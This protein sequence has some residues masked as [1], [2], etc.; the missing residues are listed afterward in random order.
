MRRALRSKW[1]LI[2]G[3]WLVQG[4]LAYFLWPVLVSGQVQPDMSEYLHT[5]YILWML[6]ILGSLMVLQS[7]FVL[8]V[9]R[10]RASG[11]GAW[12]RRLHFGLS[13]L[14]IGIM[15]GAVT[16]AAAAVL[17]DFGVNL[18]ID[19]DTWQLWFWAPLGISWP[20]AS[21][22]LARRCGRATPLR[23]SLLIAGLAAGLLVGGFV[24][25]IMS[26]IDLIGWSR[27]M[28]DEWLA[29]IF[30]VILMSWLAGTV[31]LISFTRHSPPDV[32][33]NRIASR[34]FIGTIIEAAAII[35]LD[36]MVRR[37]TDCYC[38]EGTFWAL[39]ACWAVGFLVL[40]PA[41]WLLPLSRRRRRWYL[42]RCVA[43]GYDMSGCR[44]ADRCPECGAG[45]RTTTG[46]SAA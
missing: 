2:V 13:G 40:G 30:T 45:W 32:A 38:A 7:V 43:C 26:L 11:G 16:L 18:P 1:K 24:A 20:V 23:L 19:G 42:G 27:Q 29:F 21:I 36:V 8:P 6:V 9:R 44:D 5:E 25:A 14:A 39:S 31:L 12:S 15:A 3:Y 28:E 10:P 46:E 37:K 17:V 35:P 41:I 4:L 33:L 22:M 34:L